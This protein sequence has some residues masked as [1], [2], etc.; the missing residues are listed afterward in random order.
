MSSSTVSVITHHD[1]ATLFKE[2]FLTLCELW[3][4]R[5]SWLPRSV[6]TSPGQRSGHQAKSSSSLSFCTRARTRLPAIRAKLRRTA[7]QE[8]DASDLMSMQGYQVLFILFD[9]VCQTE[10]ASVTCS[11]LP[12]QRKSILANVNHY[13]R[14]QERTTASTRSSKR[15]N[16]LSQSNPSAMFLTRRRPRCTTGSGFISASPKRQVGKMIGLT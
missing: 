11:H 9:H 3:L 14:M 15:R 7:R 10:H 16:W 4:R 2:L 5:C 12:T 6:R 1:K 13:R 8:P